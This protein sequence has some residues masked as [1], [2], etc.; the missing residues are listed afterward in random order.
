MDRAS[1]RRIWKLEGLLSKTEKLLPAVL[2]KQ[3]ESKVPLEHTFGVIREFVRLHTTSVAAIVIWGEPKVHEPLIRAWE[4][5][6]AHHR[7]DVKGSMLDSNEEDWA[8][9]DD[10]L[11][12]A[13]KMYP[14]IINDP[15][16]ER[17]HSWWDPGIVHAPESARF[18]EIF[19]TAPVWLLHFTQIRLD[20]SVLEFELPDLSAEPA[21]GADGVKDAMRWPR[22]PL[23]TM[24]AGD[25]VPQ[26]REVSPSEREERRFYQEMRD[27]P[28]EEWS[29]SERRRMSEL[30]A[31]SRLPP[32]K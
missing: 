11:R 21:W 12:P 7:I 20:A 30:M 31:R 4:R 22:L 23:G 16:Y 13:E 2:A 32:E 15:D 1:R 29:R 18:T 17:P 6:L 8:L 24:A 5:T 3:E 25:P 9:I 27:R 10:E 19:R 26:P 14:T 28:R